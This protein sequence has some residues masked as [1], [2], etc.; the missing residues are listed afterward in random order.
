MN[1]LKDYKLLI[2]LLLPYFKPLCIT[3]LWDGTAIDI[4]W[5]AY[6]A[7]SCVLILLFWLK[8][9]RKIGKLPVIYCVYSLITIVAMLHTNPAGIMGAL[10]IEGSMLSLIILI[11]MTC[12]A[13]EKSLIRAFF[14]I[15][16]VYSFIQFVL[17]LIYPNGFNNGINETRVHFLGLDN[18]FTLFMVLAF[19]VCLMYAS[20]FK[21]KTPYVVV[22]IDTLVSLYMAS[23]TGIAVTLCLLMFFVVRNFQWKNINGWNVFLVGMVLQVFVVLFNAT[24]IFSWLIVN[25]LHKDMTFTSRVYIWQSAISTIIKSPIWGTGQSSVQV[26]TWTHL[27]YAHNMFLDVGMRYGCLAIFGFIAIFAVVVRSCRCY[28][29]FYQGNLIS[30]V[31]LALM[32]CGMVEGA[33]YRVEFIAV[34]ALIYYHE[35]LASKAHILHKKSLRGNNV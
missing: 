33:E 14:T 35:S 6:R 15:V 10:I 34:L 26:R 17:I 22:V 29:D 12:H 3:N 8:S 21:K 16:S 31:I 5:N 1:V 30:I 20:V 32:L 11:E 13:S 2:F 28:F 19:F 25:V 7:F 23:G 9:Y 18:E 27:Y 24:G 4:F